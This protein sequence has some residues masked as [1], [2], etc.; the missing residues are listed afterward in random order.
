VEASEATQVSLG[1]FGSIVGEGNARAATEAD[2][3]DGVVPRFVV[4]PGSVEEASE[5]MRLASGHG[6]RVAPR[7]SGTEMGLGNPPVAVDLVVSTV[8][9]NRLLEHAAGDLVTR[10]E[11][12]MRLEDLQRELSGADQMLGLDPS[13]G[14]ATVGGLV[15]TNA[16]GPRRLRYGTVRDLLIG[17]TVVRPNGT[18]AKSGGKVVKNVAG[19]DLGKLYTGSL[20][21]LGLV[22]ETI[23]RLHPVPAASR[24][25]AVE[26][27][28]PEGAGSAVQALMHS[29]IVP[30]MIEVHWPEPDGKGVVGVLIEGIEPG[31]VAQAD[32]AVEL[33]RQ[34][35]SSR[36][37]EGAET[38][39]FW[40]GVLRMPWEPG[41][42]GLKVNALPADLPRVLEAVRD[43]A[44]RRGVTPRIAGHAATGVTRVGLTGGDGEAHAEIVRELREIVTAREGSVV[45]VQAPPELKREVD[46]WGP[47]G[48]SLPLMRRVKE[49]FDPAG[50]MNPGRFVGGI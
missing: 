6:L 9:M 2:A 39:G 14:E 16:S 20:G 12:G 10:V 8:R 24:T 34:H 49:R 43:A 13:N 31:A 45:V 1:Q 18:V 15:A 35:G 48:D 40:E 22:V 38:A 19:Y 44:G 41:D 50:I 7:G 25:V 36:V 42:V 29:T 17:I 47:V 30:S 28:N 3:I 21:T 46:A 26:V 32:S 37:L 11:A 33:T 23:W 5:V 27:D 4:E